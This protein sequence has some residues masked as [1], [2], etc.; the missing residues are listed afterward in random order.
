M[1][2][3]GFLTFLAFTM[4]SFTGNAETVK[5]L[6]V[7]GRK[8]I[9]KVPRGMELSKGD[10]MTLS[11]GEDSGGGGAMAGAMGRNNYLAAYFQYANLTP[12]GAT[13][14][15]SAMQLQAEY[16]WNKGTMEYGPTLFYQSATAGSVTSS[17]TSFG[18]FFDWNFTP[19]V[20]GQSGI[21]SAGATVSMDSTSAGAS[22]TTIDII[23]KYK[24]FPWNDSLGLIPSAAYRIV[25]ADGGGSS[26]FILK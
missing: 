26:G 6:K 25:S 2:L 12:E 9:I 10:K 23:G 1:K 24:M 11:S 15:A 20:P 7:K 16:G 21:I 5:V 8:V 14:S 18:G 3:I 4:L 17:S 13:E 22:S 19:N